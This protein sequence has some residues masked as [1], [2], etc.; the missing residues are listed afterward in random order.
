MGKPDRV[1]VVGI[2]ALVA[3]VAPV[4]IVFNSALV[5]VGVGSTFSLGSRWIS[6]R[7]V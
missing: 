7:A 3:L 4:S 2:G 5:V 1:A 6:K